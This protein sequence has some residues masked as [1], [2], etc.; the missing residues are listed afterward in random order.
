MKLQDP[1]KAFPP[2]DVAAGMAQV[3][4]RQGYIEIK[5]S[6]PVKPIVP[7]KWWVADGFIQ[8]D[9]QHPPVIRYKCGQ[10]M[11]NPGEASSQVGTAHKSV[12]VLHCGQKGVMCPP[13]VAAQYEKAFAAWKARSTKRPVEKVSAVL[14]RVSPEG[15]VRYKS[16][17]ELI[18]EAQ[19]A[20][21]K[22]KGAPHV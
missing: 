7:L 6:E 3:L 20:V 11:S 5:P 21:A 4:L 13:D 18:L 16:R 15:V 9:Y 14:P 17:E 22:Q 2:F 19:M 12:K 8:G 1:Q 10:C